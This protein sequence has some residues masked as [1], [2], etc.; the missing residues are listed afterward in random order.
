MDSGTIG[1]LI[2]LGLVILFMIALFAGFM[3]INP[4]YWWC[5]LAHRKYHTNY[6]VFHEFSTYCSKCSRHT[7]EVY[8]ID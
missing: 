1:I 7:E 5:Q 3:F 8:Y 2:L 6:G 4:K